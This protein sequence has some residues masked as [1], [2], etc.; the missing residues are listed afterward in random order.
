M[1]DD[2][3]RQIFREEAYE[4][5]AELETTLLELEGRSDDMD[6]VN[7]VFRALHTI[8]GSG[9]MFGFDDIAGFTH[10]VESVFDMVRNG[11]LKIS[12][13]LLDQ[14]FLVRDHIQRMLDEGGGDEVDPQEAGAI[15]EA[16]RG[17]SSG[18]AEVDNTVVPPQGVCIGWSGRSRWRCGK[19]RGFRYAARC[20]RCRRCHGEVSGRRGR[21]N[22]PRGGTERG[23]VGNKTLAGSNLAAA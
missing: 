16:L 17:I 13:G 4:L 9:S 15:L 21:A 11:D 19:V 1:S 22:Y 14:A 7:R 8:K 12:R 20:R 2:I 18:E 10:E 3:N 23:H 6:I 5:L